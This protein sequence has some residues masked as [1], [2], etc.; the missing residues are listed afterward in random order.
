MPYVK[1]ALKEELRPFA[2]RPANNVGELTFQLTETI[3]N[4]IAHQGL[5]FQTVSDITGALHQCQRD[6]DERVVEPYEMRKRAENGDVWAYLTEA[7]V[8]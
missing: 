6:F 2:T 8:V 7:G 4:Y 1:E 3:Q 5:A